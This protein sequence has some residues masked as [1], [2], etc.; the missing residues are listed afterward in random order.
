MMALDHSTVYGG[1]ASF[2]AKDMIWTIFVND[3]NLIS[4]TKYL[5]YLK[6]YYAVYRCIS[7]RNISLSHPLTGLILTPVACLEQTH[8]E[9][10]H[11]WL[12]MPNIMPLGLFLEWLFHYKSLYRSYDT[13]AEASLTERFFVKDEGLFS[14]Q[15]TIYTMLH[16]EY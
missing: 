1:V 5:L 9:K 4:Y 7:I 6:S 8:L 11:I 16:T 15:F 14:V 3:L 2:E 13:W 10:D 12:Y